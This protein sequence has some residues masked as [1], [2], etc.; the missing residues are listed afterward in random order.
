MNKAT[1]L[2]ALVLC[3]PWFSCHA[4]KGCQGFTLLNVCAGLVDCK[5]MCSIILLAEAATG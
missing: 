2:V 3:A 1:E 4:I 5:T